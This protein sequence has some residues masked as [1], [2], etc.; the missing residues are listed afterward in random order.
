MNVVF[1]VFIFVLFFVLTPGV[2]VRLP[3]KGSKTTVALVHSLIFAIALAVSGHF[4]WKFK[5]SFFEGATAMNKMP[6]IKISDSKPPGSETP[7]SE[8]TNN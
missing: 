4:F 8:S 5:N 1:S 7:G 3:S 2:L 6:K